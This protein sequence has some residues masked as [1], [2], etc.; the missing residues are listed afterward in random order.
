MAI[1]GAS[2]PLRQ[3]G[4]VVADGQHP[5]AWAEKTTS[6][7]AG[8]RP[9]RPH[10]HPHPSGLTG[11]STLDAACRSPC[12]QLCSPASGTVPNGESEWALR[13]SRRDAGDSGVREKS[14]RPLGGEVG[15]QH[16]VRG[17]G[18]SATMTSEAYRNRCRPLTLPRADARGPLPLPQGE[19]EECALPPCPQ[20]ISVCSF[21]SP[22]IPAYT[23]GHGKHW[24]FGAAAA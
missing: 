15:A 19:R 24:V 1:P 14:L 3:P 21:S 22:P 7:L 6:P 13:S 8:E 16:R 10:Y 5:E 17:K 4:R 23:C 9:L 11:G 12:G 2:M 20:P 18:L